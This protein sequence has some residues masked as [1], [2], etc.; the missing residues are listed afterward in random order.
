ML[1]KKKDNKQISYQMWCKKSRR[2]A[3]I[4]RSL[5]THVIP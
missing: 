2:G 1:E 3:I 5:G 4:D